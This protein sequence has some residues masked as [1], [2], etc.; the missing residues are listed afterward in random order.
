MPRRRSGQSSSAVS[1]AA[2]ASGSAP[3]L[4]ESVLSGGLPEAKA[5]LHALA[6]FSAPATG[7]VPRPSKATDGL[8]GGDGTANAGL[9][10]LAI[11]LLRGRDEGSRSAGSALATLIPLSGALPGVELLKVMTPLLR[12]KVTVGRRAV[13]AGMAEV[14]NQFLRGRVVRLFSTRGAKWQS[15]QAMP[16]LRLTLSP[17]ATTAKGHPARSRRAA[18]RVRV[19]ALAC[20]AAYKISVLD[21]APP[22]RR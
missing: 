14:L 18:K 8:S 17:P 16:S 3:S 12:K 13:L 1:A 22:T 20:R 10:K 5:L 11:S 6:V 4:Q 2:G 15:K 21:G 7:A 9:A 19:A